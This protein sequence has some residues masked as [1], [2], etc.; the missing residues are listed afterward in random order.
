[1]LWG[2]CP[3]SNPVLTLGIDFRCRGFRYAAPTQND[4]RKKHAATPPPT[5]ESFEEFSPCIRSVHASPL[6]FD[7]PGPRRLLLLLGQ[8]EIGIGDAHDD[9]VVLVCKTDAKLDCCEELFPL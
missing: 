2:C 5:L 1:M 4:E 9:A 7:A 3:R 8:H 6:L